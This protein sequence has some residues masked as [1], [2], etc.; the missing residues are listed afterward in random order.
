[1]PFST[2]SKACDVGVISVAIQNIKEARHT[3]NWN[4]QN[5]KDQFEKV[6][7]FGLNG[8]FSKS[9]ESHR[10]KYG[11]ELT[12]NSVKSRRCWARRSR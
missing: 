12:A 10:L 1:M 3:R 5:R 9:G 11:F 8:D 4:S 6:T 7:V 2:A